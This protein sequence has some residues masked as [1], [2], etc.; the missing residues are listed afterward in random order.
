MSENQCWSRK[1][2]PSSGTSR[3]HELVSRFKEP[4]FPLAAPDSSLYR[5]SFL[6][7]GVELAVPLPNLLF[8]LCPLTSDF[9]VFRNCTGKRGLRFPGVSAE[10]RP[11]RPPP[12]PT[13]F[14]ALLISPMMASC[15]PGKSVAS[16]CSASTQ[17]RSQR[18]LEQQL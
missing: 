1:G 17:R 7:E 12:V 3:V 4:Y 16:R 14:A 5:S 13:S 11:G 2:L 9:H 15:D 6:L 10:P 18:C 8:I